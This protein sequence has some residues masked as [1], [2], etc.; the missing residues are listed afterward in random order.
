M[1]HRE[2]L[3]KHGK[4]GTPPASRAS[5]LGSTHISPDLSVSGDG[6]TVTSTG[7][8]WTSGLAT[9]ALPF[10]S[11]AGGGSIS[12]EAVGLVISPTYGN[13]GMIGAA[14]FNIILDSYNR[15]A[16]NAAWYSAGR[17]YRNGN[18]FI[19]VP[20]FTVGDVVTVGIN[21]ETDTFTAYKNGIHQF[22]SPILAGFT[23]ADKALPAVSLLLG[24][25][26]RFNFGQTS[27]QYPI[28]G[29]AEGWPLA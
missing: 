22:T 23:D 5:F 17:F 4:E 19:T 26:I 6:L 29:Y 7:G 24:S 25:A 12:F 27:L 18:A 20:T 28:P 1:I 3:I 14:A 13:I 2:L 8:V 10:K 15:V 21:F 11:G 9:N 16:P